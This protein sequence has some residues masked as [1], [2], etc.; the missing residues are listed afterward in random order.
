M[1]NDRKKAFSEYETCVL[2]GKPTG[3]LQ[4]TPVQSR[5]DYVEGGGQLCPECAQ[6]IYKSGAEKT[7]D[8]SC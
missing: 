7:A 5:A 2:C 8:R 1:E 4:S 6:K 3:I